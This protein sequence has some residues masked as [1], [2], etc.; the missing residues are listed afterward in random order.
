MEARSQQLLGEEKVAFPEDGYHGE[1]IIQHAKDYISKYGDAL[2]EETPE[3]RREI[4]AQY[5]LPINIDRIRE[6]LAAYGIEYDVWFS[7]RSLHQSGEVDETIEFLTD[8]GYT[9]EKEGAIWLNGEKLGLEKDEVLVRNNGVPTIWL[10]ILPT[11]AI[12]L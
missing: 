11:I 12:S 5:A 7:E 2:L 6:M 3:K 1:D 4:L 9:T 10:Q 8:H